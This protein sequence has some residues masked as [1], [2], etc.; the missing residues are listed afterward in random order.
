MI[1]SARISPSSLVALALAIFFLSNIPAS[2]QKRRVVAGGSARSHARATKVLVDGMAAL[3]GL[4]AMRA[5][6][7]VSVKI[8]GFSYARTPKC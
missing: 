7:E 6:Q 5:G 8:K 3:G 1:N 4:E 2:A